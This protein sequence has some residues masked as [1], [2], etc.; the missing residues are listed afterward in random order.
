MNYLVVAAGSL[1]LASAAAAQDH[2]GHAGMSGM[3][4]PAAVPA[5]AA[6]AA[7]M[8]N[9]TPEE[10][11]QGLRE[12]RGM[13]LAKPA[14][15]NGYPGPRHVLEVA[16]QIGL[17]AEQRARTQQL[18]DTMRGEASRLGTDLLAKEAELNR[19]FRDHQA[20]PVLLRKTAQAIGQTEAELKIV[21]LRTHL[22]MMDILTPEQ[23]S[24]YVS[25]RRAGVGSGKT[26]PSAGTAEPAQHTH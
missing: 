11:A 2:S 18:F 25:L 3:A 17:T 19:I 13:G 10:R 26:R 21:H 23:V 14:E 7:S 16:D 22:A 24:R 4:Q 9:Y 8:M 1:A 15:G 5:S 12:G 20:T 6:S